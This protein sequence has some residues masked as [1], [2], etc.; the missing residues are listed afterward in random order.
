[1]LLDG[2]DLGCGPGFVDCKGLV[3][4]G[5]SQPMKGS[6]VYTVHGLVLETGHEHVYWPQDC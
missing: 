3:G 5:I 1:M 4:Q 2:L 6:S